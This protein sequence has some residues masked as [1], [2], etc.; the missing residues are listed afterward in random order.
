ME[1]GGGGYGAGD[2]AEM[3]EGFAD[4]LRYVVSTYAVFNSFNGS[5]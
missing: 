5:M 3:V 1:E 2:G 4:I